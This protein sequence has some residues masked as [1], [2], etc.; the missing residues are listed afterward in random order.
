MSRIVYL[1]PVPVPEG[2]AAA[3]RI[4]GI[5]KTL[6][7]A[8]FDVE[9]GSGGM[10]AGPA[11]SLID[12]IPVTRLS[13]RSADHLPRALRQ[14]MY[15]TIGRRSLR[16]LDQLD[17][18]PTSVILYGG[19][20]PYLLRLRRWCRR[21]RVPLI[22]DAVEWYQPPHAIGWASPYYWNIELAMRWLSPATGHIIAISSY[23]ADYYRAK[24]CDV[25]RIPPTLDTAAL[26]PGP[27]S[28]GERLVLAYAGTPG[29]KDLFDVQLEAVLALAD[30]GAALLLRVAGVEAATILAT[31]AMR[32][33]G[34]TALPPCVETVGLTS[35]DAARALVATADF[36]LL[37][38]EH[39]RVSEAGFP[40]KVVES[41]ALGTP[42]IGTLTGDLHRH[43]REGETA[44]LSGNAS[45]PALAAAIRRAMA[46]TPEQRDQMRANARAEAVS[47]FDVQVA[48]EALSD[49]IGRAESVKS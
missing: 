39:N 20:S 22:F 49:F 13:E 10:A 23:L 29:H 17:P 48:I 31:P 7:L 28:G 12:G 37:V 38:R 21:H 47:S 3:R 8:G 32:R 30:Q 5:A 4:L 1:S 15:M 33:R 40:T 35:G 44:L 6:Q 26:P 25:V 36:S 16:W 2:G 18:R 46:M 24:G 45:A 27:G 34:L 41:L 19:Y 9:I 14:L 11:R 43:L 42:V